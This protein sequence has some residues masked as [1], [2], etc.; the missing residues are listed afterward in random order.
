MGDYMKVA[1]IGSRNLYIQNLE[2]YLPKNITEIVSGGAFGIDRCAR[3]Y[4]IKNGL[5]IIEFLPNYEKFG[6][7]APLK[8]NDQIIQYAD[9]ILAFWDGNSMGTKYVIEKCK[10]IGK[11]IRVFVK[12]KKER[13]TT[14]LFYI[15]SLWPAL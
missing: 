2:L 7:A 15:F 1:V 13:S 3:D 11:P 10:C 5:P 6:Q 4:A 9:Q 14:C 8:R 12:T